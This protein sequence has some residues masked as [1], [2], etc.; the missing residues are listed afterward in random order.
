MGTLESHILQASLGLTRC[1][2]WKPLSSLDGGTKER[3]HHKFP[4]P[5]GWRFPLPGKGKTIE[6]TL[7]ENIRMPFL[8]LQASREQRVNFL[9]LSGLHEEGCTA[10]LNSD[11]FNIPFGPPRPASW[12]GFVK[13]PHPRSLRRPLGAR[14]LMINKAGDSMVN[15]LGEDCPPHPSRS[16]CPLGCLTPE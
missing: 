15:K 13:L 6:Q 12:L 7:G 5:R 4:T 14:G 9:W 3:F 1:P 10:A 16:G 2:L 8:A 11:L